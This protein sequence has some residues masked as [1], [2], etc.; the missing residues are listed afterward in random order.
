MQRQETI[1]YLLNL[2]VM[3]LL[4]D[5]LGLATSSRPWGAARRC[6]Y[7]ATKRPIL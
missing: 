2:T 3:P 5:A 7:D 6:V 1:S 4:D